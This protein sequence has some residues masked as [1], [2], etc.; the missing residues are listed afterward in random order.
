MRRGRLDKPRGTVEFLRTME[1]I[2]RFL[3]PPPARILDV[4][5]GPGRY[6]LDLQAAGYVVEL[7]D[8]LQAH[9]AQARSAGVK[10]ATVGDAREL[11][12]VDAA[13]D[14]VLLLGPLYHLTE[15]R[16]RV[17]AW[18]EAARV[19]LPN[20]VVIGAAISRFA[21]LIDGLNLGLLAEPGFAAIV[22]EDLPTGQ[23]RNPEHREKWF[24]T[25]YFHHPD[26][27]SPEMAEGG[28]EPELV[29]AVEGPAQTV[30][31][32]LEEWLADPRL[33]ETLL[34]FSGQGR[35]GTSDNR[36]HG[37]PVGGRAK[38]FLRRTS[39]AIYS[40]SYPANGGRWHQHQ[41][42]GIIDTC[43]SA[44]RS[45]IGTSPSSRRRIGS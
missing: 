18:S 30:G 37:S 25:A 33:R 32:A 16:D 3:P 1:I 27:L 13:M 38:T 39:I 17:R 7:V 21:S 26:E 8:V 9:V 15:R 19:V 28:L 5:G 40:D 34:A 44:T 2:G 23:H 45:G 36:F 24:T 6:A 29:A 41:C 12:F 4:G 31:P 20:G 14:S 42:Q 11:K 10:L 43:L 22:D 35:N